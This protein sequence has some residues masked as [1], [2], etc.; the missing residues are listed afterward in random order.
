VFEAGL[1]FAA[2][3][4]STLQ[5]RL[6][7]SQL[8]CLPA[9]TRNLVRLLCSQG[10]MVSTR[11]GR[12]RSSSPLTK[13]SPAKATKLAKAEIDE[14]PAK[15]TK[16]TFKGVKVVLLDIG[17]SAPIRSRAPGHLQDQRTKCHRVEGTICPITFVKETLVSRRR[18]HP[19]TLLL[20]LFLNEDESLNLWRTHHRSFLT[21]SK[22]FPKFWRV[23]G[24]R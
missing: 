13:T 8:V 18:R 5:Y 20:G 23:S 6:R 24:L 11:S 1:H 3:I 9:L 15:A 14:A 19:C 16:K 17:R 12:K 7:T 10:I 21:L 4:L 2:R 22:P